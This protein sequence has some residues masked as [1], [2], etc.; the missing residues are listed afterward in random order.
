M[1]CYNNTPSTVLGTTPHFL[2][3]GRHVPSYTSALLAIPQEVYK[4]HGEF[5][6][7]IAQTIHSA[8][9]MCNENLKRAALISK[10]YYNRHRPPPS[11]ELGDFVLCFSPKTPR[12]RAAKWF[13]HYKQEAKLIKKLSASCYLIQFKGSNRT[14]AVYAD[15]LLRLPT[16]YEKTAELITH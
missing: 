3:R 12:N 11:F 10:A 5:A 2:H 9:Q 1:D 7:R 13:Q 4:T 6:A 16:N 15:K 14:Q 8:F